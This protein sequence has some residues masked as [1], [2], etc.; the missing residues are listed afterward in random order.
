MGQVYV[1][2]NDTLFVKREKASQ[3]PTFLLLKTEKK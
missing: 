2:M 1:N 3:K